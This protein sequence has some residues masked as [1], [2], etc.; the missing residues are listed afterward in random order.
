MVLDGASFAQELTAKAQSQG[1]FLGGNDT[2]MLFSFVFFF[3]M[4]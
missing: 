1:K 4:V 2:K 3:L